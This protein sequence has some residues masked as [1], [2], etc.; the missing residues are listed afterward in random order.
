MKIRLGAI[1]GLAVVALAGTSLRDRSSSSASIRPVRVSLWTAVASVQGHAVERFAPRD[2]ADIASVADAIVI[3]YVKR[4]LG[5]TP[6]VASAGDLTDPSPETAPQILHLEV[7][8]EQVPV[9]SLTSEES[10]SGSIHVAIVVN[11]SLSAKGT[12]LDSLA[13]LQ[14]LSVPSSRVIL[15]LIR[16]DDPALRSS[17]FFKEYT[18]TSHRAVIEYVDN[19]FE[20]PLGDAQDDEWGAKYLRGTSLAETGHFLKTARESCNEKAR[21]MTR[22]IDSIGNVVFGSLSAP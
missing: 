10:A 19:R 13:D 7:A 16:E 17:G 14:S 3:G 15:S 22:Q 5:V 1:M 12:R 21:C 9:G 8:V 11:P 20:F 6:V 4:V 2:A 18:L